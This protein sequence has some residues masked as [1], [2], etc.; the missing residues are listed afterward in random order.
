VLHQLKKGQIIF[1]VAIAGGFVMTHDEYLARR[2]ELLSIRSDS[3]DSFDRT[4]LALSTGGLA[5]SITFLDR[6]GKPTNS[7]TLVLILI[8]WIGMGLVLVSNMLSFFFAQ[9]NMD[10][11]IADL[12]ENYTGQSRSRKARF[13]VERFYWQKFATEICNHLSLGFFLIGFATFTLYV[14]IIEVGRFVGH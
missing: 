12:N 1:S 11:K 5:L 7:L 8:S 6:I 2:N 10:R 13:A 3:F 4:I 14:I 9:Q